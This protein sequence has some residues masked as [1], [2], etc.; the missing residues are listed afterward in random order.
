MTQ[1]TMIH[2]RR[3]AQQMLRTLLLTFALL[4]AA[5]Q[6]HAVE[7]PWPNRGFQ[8]SASE[9]PVPDFLRELLATQGISAVIDPKVS[10]TIS[11]RFGPPARTV[12]E[13]V[14]ANYGLNWYYDGAFLYIEP[15]GEA[16][17]EV[18]AIAPGTGARVRQSLR[19]LRIQDARFPVVINEARGTATV[20]GP[21]RYVELASQ[22]VR[23]A[24]QRETGIDQAQ[25]RLFPLKYA[26]AAD[27]RTQ[28]GGKDVVVPGVATVLQNLYGRGYGGANSTGGR[29]PISPFRVG[30]ERQLRLR[31]GE[32]LNAPR[33]EINTGGADDTR[34]VDSFASGS[35]PQFHADTRS[36]A[37]LV[38]D[39]PE[40]M[41]QYEQIIAAMDTRPDLVEIEVTIMDIST[42]SLDSLGVD[43]RL[44]G[45]RFD[46]QTGNGANGPLT[47]ES[48][49][50]AAGQTGQST[51]L[52]TVLTASIGH[53]MRNFLLARVNALAKNGDASFIA[54][55]KV[56]TLNN[57]EAVLEN[58]SEFYVKVDGFQDAGLFSITAG[59][60]VR[61]TPLLV[62][63][64][65]NRGLMLS[66][67]IEDGD[68]SAQTIDNIPVVRRR[69]VN[70]QA[71]IDEGASLLIAGFSSEERVTAVSRVPFLSDVPVLG[72]LFKHNEKKR[73]NMERFYLL[74]P[75]LVLPGVSADPTALL[76]RVLPTQNAPAPAL[77][78]PG[79]RMPAAG[80]QSGSPWLGA[81]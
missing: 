27:V 62:E 71:M 22:A 52:G 37:V 76:E 65:P 1:L 59:T 57:T 70:T 56:L 66:I 13:S 18:L 67:N 12:F 49:T 44:H 5:T 2:W 42:D 61:V 10:G 7:V 53:E 35:L 9:K 26:W 60:A 38:R 24:G 40:R 31:S 23:L 25:I 73:T 30:P 51:P 39:L 20:T 41:K 21:R 29:T 81:Q 78:A 33:I 75:R 58:M 77:A 3:A 28:R 14:A 43:W 72:N 47:W 68:L 15:A 48:A 55:P 50:T 36:N 63:Q 80:E 74:S 8:I 45:R 79:T 54:K 34:S 4:L 32:T 64:A 11:G 69:T 6:A 17:S 16:R 19:E 46:L